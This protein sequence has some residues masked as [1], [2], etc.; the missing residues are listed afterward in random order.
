MTDKPASTDTYRSAAQ[1]NFKLLK[2]L[3][4]TNHKLPDRDSKHP[5]TQ[6]VSFWKLG[7]SFDTMVD[8]LEMIDPSSA[9]DVAE[10]AVVQLNAS[11]KALKGGYDGAW[12]DDFGWW[13]AATA[14]ALQKP[15]FSPDAKAK[16][17][18]ILDQCWPRFTK[19]A[20]FVWER[21]KPGTVSPT[22]GKLFDDCGPAVDGGVWNAYWL[23]TPATYRGPDNGDPTDGALIG[24]QNTVT[25]ALYLMAAHR[26]SA[27]DL[28]A[29][30]AAE[31]E[32]QFLLTW[33]DQKES[34]LWWKLD[35]DAGLVRE[36]VGYYAHVKP[37]PGFQ[38]RWF[39]TGDQGLMLGNLSD[40]MLAAQPG[41]R[42]PYLSRAQHLISGVR[43]RLVDGSNVVK[44]YSAT[45]SVPGDDRSDYQVGSG[46][47]WRNYLYVWNTNPDLRTFL[48]RSE[49]TAMV[50]ASADAAAKPLTGNESIETLTNQTAVLVTATATAP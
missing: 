34:A 26:L 49:Y 8:F 48:Q 37:A 19:N 42:G 6:P 5:N 31:K 13:S 16:F 47:F 32:L 28:A 29:R 38:E 7:N 24:I 1:K 12:F 4:A 10:I 14:R 3:Y 33:F 39:W 45:G 21:R 35:D 43:Q 23:A 41:L 2:E 9:N 20:P 36:R 11:L 40:A 46:V 30:Q 44:D 25:N 22:T 17:H 18:N 50:R 27:T 15:F